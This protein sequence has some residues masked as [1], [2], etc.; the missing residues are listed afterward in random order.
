METPRFAPY[1]NANSRARNAVVVGAGIGGATAALLLARAGLEVTLFERVPEPRAVGAGLLLQPNGLAVLQGLGLGPALDARGAR[2]T[3]AAILSGTGRVLAA[4]A[5]PGVGDVVPHALALARSAVM[6]V[7][8]EAVRAEPRID[9]RLGAA[10]SGALADG[11]GVALDPPGAGREERRADLVVGADG[12]HSRLR[13]YVDPAA[14]EVPVGYSYVRGMVLA[15]PPERLGEYWTRFGLFGATPVNPSGD[16]V[17]FF[18]SILPGP[19]ADAVAARDLAAYRRLWREALPLAGPILDAVGAF[20]DLLVTEVWRVDCRTFVRGRVGLIGDAA[21]AMA[22]NL[23]QG[24]NSAIVDA[25]VLVDALFRAR[26]VEA[27]LGAFDR[28]RR[29]AVRAVQDDA[30][31]LARMAQVQSGLLRWMRDRA[32]PLATR[33]VGPERTARRVLQE[34]VGW[35]RQVAGRLAVREGVS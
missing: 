29:S 17:Y 30:D 24:A 23:G 20:D 3:R 7:L 9:L 4:Q 8:F 2:L 5:I 11:S 27:A 33:L 13:A 35:L 21:H 31:R 26:S 1:A 12:Q 32:L 22:P 34:D 16:A 28:R 18:T 15:R 6:D 19:V 25:A 14:R 10:V